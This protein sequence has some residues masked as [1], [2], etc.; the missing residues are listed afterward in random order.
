M[1]KGLITI[2]LLI[3]LGLF[4]S[5]EVLKP[6]TTANGKAYK[7][8]LSGLRTE[9]E[10]KMPDFS[11]QGGSPSENGIT[12]P[13]YA[14]GPAA[15]INQ[16][17]HNLLDTIAYQNLQINYVEGFTIQVY[18]GNRTEDARKAK[19]RAM[20]ILQN[21][22]VSLEYDQPNFK[23]K[24]GNYYSRFEA[25]KDFMQLRR[26]FPN[27]IVIMHRIPIVKKN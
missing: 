13:D 7:E 25:Q 26:S 1:N 19:G 20:E 10:S 4:S 24:A 14:F 8:D 27:A 5:C 15:D 2:G 17:L 23:V 21:D 16:P 12:Y 9:F 11:D 6:K 18:S 22:N 3:W